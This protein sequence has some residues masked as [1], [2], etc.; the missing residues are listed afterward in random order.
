MRRGE[1]DHVSACIRRGLGTLVPLDVLELW[2]ANELQA[3]VSSIFHFTW[4]FV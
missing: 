4:S 2:T 1:F 3:K